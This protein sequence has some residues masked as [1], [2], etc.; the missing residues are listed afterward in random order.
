MPGCCGYLRHSV[1]QGVW[2]ETAHVLE[3]LARAYMWAI[4]P[5]CCFYAVV[6]FVCNERTLTCCTHYRVITALDSHLISVFFRDTMHFDVWPLCV[7][8]SRLA[9]AELVRRKRRH[10][11]NNTA[12]IYL[13][14]IPTATVLTMNSWP[15][16]FGFLQYE[17]LCNILYSA[18]GHIIL[19]Y[20]V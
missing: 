7:V 10:L 13:Q 16:N 17:K 9:A 19:L 14:P 1:V 20:H 12:K 4:V 5:L 6:I 3:M 8:A 15:L 11:P 2:R 18:T